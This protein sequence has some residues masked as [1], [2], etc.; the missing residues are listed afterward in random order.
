[1]AG[2]EERGRGGAEGLQHP[3]DGGRSAADG[4]EINVG[5]SRSPGDI[6]QRGP[7]G[8][9]TLQGNQDILENCVRSMRR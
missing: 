6:A 3:R 2:S 7:L 8:P 9:V 4:R 5:H 1:M